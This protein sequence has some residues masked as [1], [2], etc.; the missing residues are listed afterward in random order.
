MQRPGVSHNILYP[1]DATFEII[2]LP[3]IKKKSGAF[4]SIIMLVMVNSPPSRCFSGP[5]A[6]RFGLGHGWRQGSESVSLDVIL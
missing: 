1:L 6:T 2:K 5:S 3:F 4:G